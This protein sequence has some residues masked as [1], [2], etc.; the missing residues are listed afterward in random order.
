MLFPECH[1]RNSPEFAQVGFYLAALFDACEINRQIC[2][3]ISLKEAGK[4]ILPM[5][6]IQVGI[7]TYM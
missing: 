3:D 7:F 4:D 2:L 5:Y 6:L 1:V